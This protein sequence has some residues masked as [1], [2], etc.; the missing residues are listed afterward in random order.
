MTI[1]ENLPKRPCVCLVSS[2]FMP[3]PTQKQPSEHLVSIRV[4]QW[5]AAETDRLRVR[6]L[7]AA[8]ERADL[9]SAAPNASD[10][11]RSIGIKIEFA[12]NPKDQIDRLHSLSHKTNQFAT[13]IVACH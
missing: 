3:D 1:P 10:Y 5:R 7:A 8:R 2:V 6:D 12:L 13:S 11:L 4:F 9:E